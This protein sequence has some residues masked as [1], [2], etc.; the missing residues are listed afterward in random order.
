MIGCTVEQF[1][2]QLITEPQIIRVGSIYT[3]SLIFHRYNFL[4]SQFVH[5][6]LAEYLQ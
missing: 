6:A 4:P 2:I 1:N 5:K 3:Q